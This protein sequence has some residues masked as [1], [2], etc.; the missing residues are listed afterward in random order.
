[1]DIHGEFAH[2]HDFHRRC[3]NGRRPAAHHPA[4]SPGKVSDLMLPLQEVVEGCAM[5][6]RRAIEAFFSTIED[7]IREPEG[8]E[9]GSGVA[10][11][12]SRSICCPSASRIV[13][14]TRF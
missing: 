3:R 12:G 9:A 7:W 4:D 1:M 11:F 5:D 6:E 8:W 2:L 14:P 10:A 13:P